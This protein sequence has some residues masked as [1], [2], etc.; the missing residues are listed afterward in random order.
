MVDRKNVREEV[1]RPNIEM[2]CSYICMSRTDVTVREQKQISS[3]HNHG[4]LFLRKRRP[5]RKNDDIAACSDRVLADFMSVYHD[6]LAKVIYCFVPFD[7]RIYG[8]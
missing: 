8:V 3:N 5:V 1:S 6:Q 7:E 4:S 2:H